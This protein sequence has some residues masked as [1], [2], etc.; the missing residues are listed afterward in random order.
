MDISHWGPTV[1]VSAKWMFTCFGPGILMNGNPMHRVKQAL[2]RAIKYQ[3]QD[4]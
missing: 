2:R 3:G 1:P 4:R